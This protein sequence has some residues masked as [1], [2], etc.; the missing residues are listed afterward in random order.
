MSHEALGTST[1][2]IFFLTMFK[3]ETETLKLLLG[4]CKVTG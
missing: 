3:E 2:M 1:I 4:V